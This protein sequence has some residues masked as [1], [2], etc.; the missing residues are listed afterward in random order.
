MGLYTGQNFEVE[1]LNTL[2]STCTSDMITFM[3]YMS[4]LMILYVLDY[5]QIKF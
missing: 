3:F 4:C 1:W 2:V 5:L